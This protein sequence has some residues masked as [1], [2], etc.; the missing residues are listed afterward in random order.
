MNVDNIVHCY[1]NGVIAIKAQQVNGDDTTVQI[2][3]VTNSA[4]QPL[5]NCGGNP[6]TLA[7]LGA[8]SVS[9]NIVGAGCT[10]SK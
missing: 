7:T 6:I 5:V 4:S 10:A 8:P 1:N 3:D 2:I 9:P